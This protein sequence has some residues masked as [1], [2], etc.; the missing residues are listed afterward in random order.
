MIKAKSALTVAAV[1]VSLGVYGGGGVQRQDQAPLS[2]RDILI[3]Q[4]DTQPAA[5]GAEKSTQESAKMGEGEGTHTGP[6]MGA[7]P[8]NDTDKIDQPD[9]RNMTSGGAGTPASGQ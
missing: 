4:N 5:G 1:A 9:R 8:E 2:E 3:V 7:T 6:N